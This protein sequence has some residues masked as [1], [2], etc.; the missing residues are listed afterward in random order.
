MV[1]AVHPADGLK[2]TTT[3]HAQVMP[4]RQA[5]KTV[6]PQHTAAARAL[7]QAFTICLG[8]NGT[9]QHALLLPHQLLPRQLQPPP[10][11]TARKVAHAVSS[12]L[13]SCWCG[14]LVLIILVVL[15]LL[16]TIVASS[17]LAFLARVPSLLQG[18]QEGQGSDKV[19]DKGR[20]SEVVRDRA[21]WVGR[22]SCPVCLQCTTGLT[23]LRLVAGVVCAARKSWLAVQE[24][25]QGYD[26]GC[27]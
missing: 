24:L 26:S 2:P 25:C 16:L 19:T 15:L 22:H 21:G 9:R 20:G 6:N 23:Q 10:A 17:A 18:Q 5:K 8:A 13:G 7:Q 27:R 4:A 1:H 11:C 3:I 12:F 14:L